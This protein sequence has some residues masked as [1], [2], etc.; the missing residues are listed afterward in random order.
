MSSN[1]FDKYSNALSSELLNAPNSTFSFDENKTKIISKIL[2]KCTNFEDFC[3]DIA[4]GISTGCDSVYI[5]NESKIDKNK[6]EKEYLKPTIRGN[7]FNKYYCP[8][9]TGDYLLYI[10]PDFKKE[11]EPNIYRYLEDNK[12]L[13][14]NKSVEKKD[15]T[16]KWYLLFRHR[17]ED[18]FKYSKII[19]RQT[20][21]KIISAFDEKSN[22]FCIDSVNVAKLKNIYI[23]QAK[24]FIAVLNSQ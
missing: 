22:Y 7:Q 11:N 19:I 14:I 10:T 21:D 13:L 23:E 1:Y 12:D 16:R 20:G 4:N 24:F 15:G 2:K 8:Q 6:F 9:S 17:N 5:V 18:L 3:D